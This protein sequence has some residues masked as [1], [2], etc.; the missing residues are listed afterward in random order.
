MGLAAATVIWPNEFLL[1]WPK[2]LSHLKTT[3]GQKAPLRPLS[4]GKPGRKVLQ[5]FNSYLI[6]GEFTLAQG[7]EYSQNSYY[8]FNIRR[9]F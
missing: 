4:P 2:P 7:S 9:H 3:R 6:L 1:L 5:E 8:L